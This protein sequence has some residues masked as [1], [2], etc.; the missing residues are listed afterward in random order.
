[1]N[2]VKKVG[3]IKIIVDFIKKDSDNILTLFNMHDDLTKTP[4]VKCT[5]EHYSEHPL[6]R[7]FD[8]LLEK[9]NPDIGNVTAILIKN[10]ATPI[11]GVIGSIVLTEAISIKRI[12]IFPGWGLNKLSTDKA[13]FPQLSNR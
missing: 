9:G 5:N 12:L 7:P 1:M 11:L 2:S 3:T 4:L 8:K 13:Y 10:N 6:I